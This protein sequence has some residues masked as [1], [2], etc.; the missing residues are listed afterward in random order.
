VF[1]GGSVCFPNRWDLRSK[2][3]LTLR[4]VHEPVALL[5]EQLAAPV[6]RV[7]ERL[8]PGRGYWRLGWGVIDVP[9]GYTP[10]D[11]SGVPRPAD[12]QPRDLFVRVERE[13]L[14]RFPRTN[15]VLFTIRTYVANIGDV[16]RDPQVGERMATAIEVMPPAVRRYKDLAIVGEE[17]VRFLRSAPD[18]R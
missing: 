18:Q 5:N 15:C 13:T 11:G 12:P 16:A 1:G 9:D 7:L 17:L 4:E 10:A 6:D 2:L 3:G 14:R 8:T